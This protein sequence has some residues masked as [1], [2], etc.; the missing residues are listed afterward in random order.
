MFPR[1]LVHSN[2]SCNCDSVC[3]F[4][5]GFHCDPEAQ[6]PEVMCLNTAHMCVCMY[7]ISEL[8]TQLPGM[9]RFGRNSPQTF[10]LDVKMWL[11][12]PDVKQQK[13]QPFRPTSLV[14]D[15][16]DDPTPHPPHSFARSLLAS[17]QVCC[18]GTFASHR[19]IWCNS[20]T[21]SIE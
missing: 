5:P 10:F 11:K 21:H 13:N 17:G 3:L 8:N 19:R 2:C 1:W 12:V 16:D 15:W 14:S 20:D 4:I 7:S 9:Q 6:T 18:R